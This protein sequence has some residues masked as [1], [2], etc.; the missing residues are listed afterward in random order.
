MSAK[1]DQQ[2]LPRGMKDYST[3]CQEGEEKAWRSTFKDKDPVH[4]TPILFSC[5]VRPVT[6]LRWL[7]YRRQTTFQVQKQRV[8]DFKGNNQ[9]KLIKS[10]IYGKG[11][12]V[13]LFC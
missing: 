3:L 1:N 11:L 7:V 9:K 13:L 12:C 4:L 6:N 2:T 8:V 5:S 10:E